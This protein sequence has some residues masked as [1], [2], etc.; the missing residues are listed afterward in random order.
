MIS[1]NICGVLNNYVE[2]K[3]VIKNK[4]PE[5]IMLNETHLVE[6]INDAEVKING[7]HILRTDSHSSH[8][9]G[10]C[11]LGWVKF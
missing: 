9:G 3:Y 1:S 2:L 7:F 4:N 8:T 6:E 11:I 10:T 5:F